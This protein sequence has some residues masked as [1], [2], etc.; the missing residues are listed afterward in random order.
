MMFGGIARQE[1][2]QSGLRESNACFGRR[3]I[4]LLAVF[5]REQT[6]SY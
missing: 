1:M 6:D 3:L 2:I 5:V 4:L